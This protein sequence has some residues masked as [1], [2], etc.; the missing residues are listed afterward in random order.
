MNGW[1]WKNEHIQVTHIP[2]NKKPVLLIGNE[3]LLWKIASF[4]SE[5][6]ADDFC[7]ML[8]RWLGLDGRG[9]NGNL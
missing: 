2:K 7:R 6:D 8:N 3:Y 9:E 4:D 5:E 1:N